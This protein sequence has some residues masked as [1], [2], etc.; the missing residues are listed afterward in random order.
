MHRFR[1]N[2]AGIRAGRLTRRGVYWT[3]IVTSLLVESAPSLAV[4]RRA[5]T[6]GDGK[7]AAVTT[8]PPATGVGPAGS[9][10]IFDGPLNCIQ[11]TVNP[12]GRG[13]ADE[14]ACA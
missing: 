7:R 12:R 4:A 6:P 2:S 8:A 13:A 5:Y 9:N 1:A 14:L 3:V 10:E 11:V